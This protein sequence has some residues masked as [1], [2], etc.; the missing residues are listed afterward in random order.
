MTSPDTLCRPAAPNAIDTAPT[1]RPRYIV[2]TVSPAVGTPNGFQ[3]RNSD[4]SVGHRAATISALIRAYQADG[5]RLLQ[6]DQHDTQLIFDTARISG[7]DVYDRLLEEVAGRA[8]TGLSADLRKAFVLGSIEIGKEYCKSMITTCAASTAAY[9]TIMGWVIKGAASTT[10]AA[11]TV[12]VASAVSVAQFIAPIFVFT[13]AALGFTNGYYAHPVKHIALQDTSPSLLARV[14]HETKVVRDVWTEFGGAV[15]W[16]GVLSVFLAAGAILTNASE[17][18]RR[19]GAVSAAISA[20]VALGLALVLL[21]H[22]LPN[23]LAIPTRSGQGFWTLIG[24]VCFGAAIAVTVLYGR[25]EHGASAA[26][27]A[28]PAMLLT[29]YVLWRAPRRAPY[30]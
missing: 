13:I 8:E 10:S 29:A 24:A 1:G 23:A 19:L 12:T 9:L 22:S 7:E 21:Y 14:I 6:R 11:A 5:W 16:L 26:F 17:A 30:S 20:L 4:A 2:V 15:Y 28:I 25:P 27:A 18:I 3:G